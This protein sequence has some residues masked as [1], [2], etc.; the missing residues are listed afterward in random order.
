M[1]DADR[2]FPGLIMIA[3]QNHKNVGFISRMLRSKSGTQL[4]VKK[5]A[6]TKK[7][8]RDTIS[9]ANAWDDIVDAFDLD[10]SAKALSE[11]NDK[12]N[13][14]YRAFAECSIRSGRVECRHLW[15]LIHLPEISSGAFDTRIQA[16]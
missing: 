5:K 4:F 9:A 2:L 6:I 14:I 10:I 3:Q 7:M 1:S 12:T 16:H 13:V 15:Y 11:S 8:L